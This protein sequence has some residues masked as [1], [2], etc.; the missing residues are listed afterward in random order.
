[1][2]RAPVARDAVPMDAIGTVFLAIGAFALLQVAAVHLRGERRH[3]AP[4]RPDRSHRTG[5]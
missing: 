4:R 1:M 2:S 5:R 3:A